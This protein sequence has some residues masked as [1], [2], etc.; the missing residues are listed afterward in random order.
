M[1]AEQVVSQRI[2]WLGVA[3]LVF[4]M[5]T[6]SPH[7]SYAQNGGP[8]RQILRYEGKL[9]GFPRSQIDLRVAVRRGQPMTAQF[10]AA[11]VP[12]SCEDGTP[13]RLVTFPRTSFRF[14][15]SQRFGGYQYVRD[16]GN[17]QSYYEVNGRVGASGRHASGALLY[18]EDPWDPP[19]SYAP[20]CGNY[21]GAPYRW[22][23][24][25]ID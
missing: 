9:I 19:G 11:E 7:A 12:V 13:P 5:A 16:G 25:R 18:F 2:R 4:G 15:G 14:R 23:A 17:N 20:D 22:K 8:D 1:H 24:E 6:L 21:S 10:G 3:L